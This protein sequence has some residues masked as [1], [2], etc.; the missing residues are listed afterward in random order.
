MN[1]I[2]F[3]HVVSV[4]QDRVAPE[5]GYLAGYN[6]LVQAYNLEIPKPDVL[7]LISHKHRQYRTAEWQV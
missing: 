3:S 5:D 2:Q 4:F 6:A 7:S 1:N